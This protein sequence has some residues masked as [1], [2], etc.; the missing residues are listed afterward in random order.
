MSRY[1]EMYENESGR[2]LPENAEKLDALFDKITSGIQLPPRGQQA[3]DMG[4]T[5]HTLSH[6]ES[7]PAI[8]QYYQW[9]MKRFFDGKRINELSS[10]L[11][12]MSFSSANIFQ[13]NLPQPVTLNPWQIDLMTDVPLMNKKAVII[14]NNGVFIWLHSLHPEW[15]LI[16]QSGNDFNESYN[17]LLKYLSNNNLKM[18]YL[19]DLDSAGIRIA[20]RVSKIVNQN[21]FSIQTPERVVDWLVRFGINDLNRTKRV[22]VDNQ[23][24]KEEITSI[25]TFKMFVEQEQLISEYEPLIKKWLQ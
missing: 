21:L 18:A 19:G 24:L 16:N 10:Q 2:E 4:F 15:P 8:Y 25:H 5:A 20:D 23:V 1:T 9:I 6:S 13:T 7:N 11:I 14:E 22:S 3:V 12:G 17:K